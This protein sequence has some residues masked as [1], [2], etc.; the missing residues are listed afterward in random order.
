MEHAIIH[1]NLERETIKPDKLVWQFLDHVSRYNRDHLQTEKL[2]GIACPA[3]RSKT[4]ETTFAK[5]GLQYLSCA[6]CHT[7]YVSPRPS[8]RELKRYF[9]ESPA[10]Q[11][12][13]KQIWEQ[14]AE[15]RRSKILEPFLD[16]VQ[17]FVGQYFPNRS[18]TV[19]ELYPVHW[20]LLE[21]WQ[22]KGLEG[23]YFLIEPYFVEGLCPRS[24]ANLSLP[25]STGKKF[26]VICLPDTLAWTSNPQDLF[27][28]VVEHLQPK[29]ICFLTTIFSSGFDV[30]LLKDRA[31]Y[32]VPPERLN[33]FSFEALQN[34]VKQFS[35][36]ILECSTPGVLDMQNV[37]EAFC[38]EEAGLPDFVKYLFKS[39]NRQSLFDSFQEFLQANQLSSQGRMV[40]QKNDL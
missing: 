2:E 33:L 14:T 32:F 40:L 15:I 30:L 18:V 23:G 21:M 24:L 4:T 19:A 7:V 1:N 5:L 38:K 17:V 20:G 8:Q 6:S 39:R 27:Q 16:W 31:S 26:D 13:L 25:F 10:R 28:W 36:E 29:G 22:E 11:F 35:F 12:W 9:V 3:C 34:L 37:Y